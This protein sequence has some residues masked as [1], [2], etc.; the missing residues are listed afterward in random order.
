[1]KIR[2]PVAGVMSIIHRVTG[3][4]MI[5]ATPILIY[6]LDLSLQGDAGFVAAVDLLRSMPG[7]I[8]LLGLL[9]A[10][11]HH[12]FAGIR[13]LLIDIDIGVDKPRYRQTA[14]AV[15]VAAPLAAVILLGALR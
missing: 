4:L 14:W 5:L 6:L 2:L 15:L 13:Y 8:L 3:V 1:M 7:Q 9:W 10:V 12:L 11:L